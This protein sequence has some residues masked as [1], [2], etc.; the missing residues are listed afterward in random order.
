MN[1]GAWW[2][3]VHRIA[4]SHTC[5]SNW[6]CSQLAYRLPGSLSRSLR[7]VTSWQAQEPQD[8]LGP[9]RKDK[10]TQTLGTA[11]DIWWQLSDGNYLAPQPRA[12]FR[13]PISHSSWKVPANSVLNS[14]RSTSILV[15]LTGMIKPSWLQLDKL[16]NAVSLWLSPTEMG[17]TEERECYVLVIQLNEYQVLLLLSSFYVMFLNCKLD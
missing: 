16:A 17:V 6:A 10:F 4:K 8:G 2:A 15:A 12:S 13:S 5:Q 7:K 9:S 14:T 3:T 1:R 11:D